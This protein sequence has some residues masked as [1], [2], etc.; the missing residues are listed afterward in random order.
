MG[1]SKPSAEYGNRITGQYL[2]LVRTTVDRRT[3][4]P[5]ALDAAVHSVNIDILMGRC[6]FC[7]A[8]HIP[9]G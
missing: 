9:E 4:L 2:R 8:V 7:A 5:S 1:D 3:S 6:Y